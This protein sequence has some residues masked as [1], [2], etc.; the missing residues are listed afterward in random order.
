MSLLRVPLPLRQ[1]G[2]FCW[3]SAARGTTCTTTP[4][5]TARSLRWRTSTRRA[6]RLTA[7]G[8]IPRA[9]AVRWW[10]A[11]GVT[12]GAVPEG[13]GGRSRTRKPSCPASR[14]RPARP[15]RARLWPSRARRYWRGRRTS[16]GVP[17]SCTTRGWRCVRGTGCWC[18]LA[19]R[20]CL[21]A[22]APR[23]SC[24]PSTRCTRRDS[25]GAAGSTTTTRAASPWPARR[26]P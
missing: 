19:A 25:A 24:A 6:P 4:R 16:V 12:S 21:A 5:A 8:L 14:P 20:A 1:A 10:T 7:P 3:V 11:T 22:G 18:Q 2:T 26:P 13:V 23:R 15:R 17:R 9:T